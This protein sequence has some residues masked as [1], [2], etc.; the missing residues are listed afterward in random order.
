MKKIADTR[1]NKEFLQVK[2]MGK[3]LYM[4]MFKL[5]R[6]PRGLDRSPEYNEH[7]CYKLDFLAYL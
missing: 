1:Y 5:T 2:R 6:A 3:G 7:F 4:D